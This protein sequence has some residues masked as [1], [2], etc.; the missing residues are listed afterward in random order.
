MPA[1]SAPCW[2]TTSSPSSRRWAATATGRPIAS[3]PTHVAVEV[4]R[5]LEAV[6]LIYLTTSPGI[7]RGEQ[8]LRQLSLE[9]AETILKKQRS[10]VATETLSKL[11]WARAGGHGGVPRVHVIDGR[12]EEAL[13]AEVFSNAGRRNAGP[14][15]RVQVHPQGPE[16]GRSASSTR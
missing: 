12:A 7:R 2:P 4:A 1:C 11:E 13:L 9:E 5:A 3:T 15:Q 14:R 8:L 16:E 6:K 10:E